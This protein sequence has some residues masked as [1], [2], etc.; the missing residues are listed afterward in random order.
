MG[1]VKKAYE[2]SEFVYA[3]TDIIMYIFRYPSGR[4]CL[5]CLTSNQPFLLCGHHNLQLNSVQDTALSSERTC[6]I[7]GL[8]NVESATGNCTYEPTRPFVDVV[9]IVAVV[10]VG[11]AVVVPLM[12]IHIN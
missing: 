1:Y 12:Q 7:A 8:L 9:G 6:T 3:H 10:I 11:A 5:Y 2:S 4:G